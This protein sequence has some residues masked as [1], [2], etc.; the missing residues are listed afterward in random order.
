MTK[1]ERAKELFLSG[2]NCAQA[3]LL[4]FAED[5]RYSKELALKLAAG[6]GG[7][8]G[9]MQETCGALTGAMMVLGIINGEGVNNNDD[10][11]ANAYAAVREL[12]SRFKERYDS[13]QCKDLTGCD[14]STA[15]G[16]EKF[17]DGKIMELV[18][19]DCVA[20]AVMILEQIAS[21]K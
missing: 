15:E 6:F 9:K 11:K 21:E 12:T 3:V 16:A 20:E 8:M 5:F 14:F 10:L 4:S 7:G 17:K 13:T 2:N 19:A 1:S 18:C